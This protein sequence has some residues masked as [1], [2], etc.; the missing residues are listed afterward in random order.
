ML[1]QFPLV[2][3]HT[4]IKAAPSLFYIQQPMQFF[5]AIL[6]VSSVLAAPLPRVS[7]SDVVLGGALGLLGTG[8]AL[9]Y[10]PT[11]ASKVFPAAAKVGSQVDEIAPTV[12]KSGET[13]AQ[14]Q[15]V[16]QSARE[17]DTLVQPQAAAAAG[18]GAAAVV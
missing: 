1:K 17:L 6:S 4:P 18:R 16:S 3:N 11:L 8:L 13:I 7:A 2:D 10:S 14:P 5:I 9:R 15:L 12:L